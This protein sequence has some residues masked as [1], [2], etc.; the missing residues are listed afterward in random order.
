MKDHVLEKALR[1]N[2]ETKDLSL[3]FSMDTR[4]RRNSH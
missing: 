2:F 1:A 3:R 4:E